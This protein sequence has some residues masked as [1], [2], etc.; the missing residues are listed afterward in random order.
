MRV[1]GWMAMA[2]VAALTIACDARDS[3]RYDESTATITDSETVGTSGQAD[4]VAGTDAELFA[5]Q[6]MLANK[7]EVK[8][9]EL[10]GERA[11][12]PA[13]KDFARMMVRDHGNALETL[14]QAVR[15]FD[16]DEP[17]QLDAKHQALYDRLS[18]LSGAEFDREYMKAMVDGHREVVDM[19]DNRAGP[20]PSATGT[21]GT[22]NSRLDAS[23]N[24]WTSKA[25][26]TTK[27][28]LQK[29]EQI[30]GQLRP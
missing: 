14:K 22:D 8:L 20:S 5:R 30:S 25:L 7:A 26:P 19:L 29:A 15:G 13:V 12:S 21:S 3:S 24:Q 27:Q 11:Q 16:V 10:A 1:N 4:R 6:A 28:H 23:V 9:G 18:K 2:C 17:A